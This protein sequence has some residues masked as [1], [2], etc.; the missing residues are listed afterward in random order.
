MI[1]FLFSELLVYLT[2]VLLGAFAAVN[3]ALAND[4]G[5]GSAPTVKP[6]SARFFETHI[7]PLFAKH[8][9]E[10]HDSV[11][12]DGELDLTLKTAA[13]AGGGSGDTIV[14]G[15]S[16]RSSLWTLVESD[17]M[18]HNRAPLSDSEKQWLK[19]WIDA[20]AVWTIEKIDPDAYLFDSRAAET[21][22]QRLTVVEYIETVRSTVGVDIADEARRLLPRD[23]R[24]DGFTN[25]SYNLGVDLSH[26]EAYARLAKIIVGRMDVPAFAANYVKCESLDAACMKDLITSMG[27]PLLRGPLSQQEALAY[28]RVADAVSKAGGDFPEAVGYVLQAMLQSPRFVYRIE[29]QSGDGATLQAD[30]YELA[31]RLSYM[32]WGGPPDDLLMSAA[33]AGELSDPQKLEAQA[34]RMLRDPRAV[35]RS[36]QF[37]N[38]WIDLNRLETLRPNPQHFPQW[39]D[40]LAAD[41]RDETLAFFEDLVWQQERPLWELMN[42]QFTYATPRLAHH[43]GLL[44]DSSA[45]TQGSDQDNGHRRVSQGLQAL[46]RFDQRGG[47]RVGDV[48]QAGE[49]LDLTIADPTGVT[50][51]SGGLAIHSGTIIA[52]EKPPTRLVGAIKKSNAITLEAWVTPATVSQSGPARILTLSNNANTRN[53]TLGQSG[54][55]FEIRLRSTKTSTNGLP[56]LK[57]RSGTVTV[58]PQH[59]V[60]T[61]DPAGNAAVYVDGKEAGKRKVAGDFGNWDDRFLLALGNELSGDRPWQGT[62]HLVAIFDR[63]LS[64]A[65]VRRNYE[66]GG[67]LEDE[68]ASLV[69]ASSWERADKRDLLALYR[70]DEGQG[71]LVRDQSQAGGK[72]DLKIQNQDAVRWGASGLMIDGSTLI[73]T[74]APAKRLSDA[75]K[76][77]KALTLEAWVTPA[78][79]AQDG[80]ARILT[81]SNGSSSRNFTLGQDGNRYDVRLRSERTD[82]NGLPSQASNGDAVDTALTH[83]VF[84]KE[85]S[86]QTRLYVNGEEQAAGDLGS[87]LSKWDN[88]FRLAIANETSKDRPWRGTYHLIAIYGRAMTA[89]EVREKG[90]GMSR[91]DL[92]DQPARGGLLT[93][94]SVLTIGGDEASM[95]SRGLFVLHDLLYS[96]V[97]NPPACVDTT[98][99]PSKPGMSMRGQAEVRLADSSCVGCHAR[100]EPLAFGLEKFDGIGAYHETDHHGNQLREDGEILFPGQA[101]PTKYETASELMDLL[102]ASDRVRMAITRKV[103]QF[104]LGR[105]LIAA[106]TPD[107]QKIHQ[108]ALS[109]GGTY[110]ALM[111]AIVTS[112]LVRK[113]RTESSP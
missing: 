112:D 104:A 89:A 36:L 106:D 108:Q 79:K 85:N 97:G 61:R 71:D 101:K 48:S 87:D 31:S 15:N 13:L 102:A 29:R 6:D 95:V 82:G 96:R 30:D 68:L 105:P 37:I 50:W 10:C 74:A 63:A 4:S 35:T 24:A 83:V 91:Y 45:R 88:G 94:A 5:G 32:L 93:Q 99:I 12:K 98:P 17:E 2:L 44:G 86:G 33:D 11:T 69:V 34:R 27:K 55:Q 7:A 84:T 20:G 28:L 14:P 107:L 80:P 60:Y 113:T 66:A 90:A 58:A 9:L 22:V 62:L 76:K 103:S 47:D 100:F 25:T 65:E 49:P 70:F 53:F 59:V 18:P 42:A 81:L 43:Y 1:R 57:S 39:N 64:A 111:T 40:Q 19:Q 73:S 51:Q 56:E 75:I 46:Y 26:V 38:E 41:M 3:V 72:L 109:N 52:S 67:V 54:D 77:S 78:T 23:E 21:W 16:A 8:C 110:P 92:A